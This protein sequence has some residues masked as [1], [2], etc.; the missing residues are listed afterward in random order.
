M[1]RLFAAQARP[2][3]EQF[4][5]HVAIT[6]R[7]THKLDL[8]LSKRDFQPEVAHDCRDHDIARKL[9]AQIQILSQYQQHRIAINHGRIG[10]TAQ[11]LYDTIVGIQYGLAPDT[12]GW[13]IEV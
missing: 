8:E 6:H 9:A 11:R 1:S 12:R 7:R 10:E 3:A 4:F 2:T 5:Q 13:T